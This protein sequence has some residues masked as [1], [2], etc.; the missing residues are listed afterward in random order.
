MKRFEF[1]T[2]KEI[3]LKYRKIDLITNSRNS[4]KLKAKLQLAKNDLA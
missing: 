1:L 4:I 2:T 3:L